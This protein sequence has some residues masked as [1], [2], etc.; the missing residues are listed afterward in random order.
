MYV[1]I[2]VIIVFLLGLYMTLTYKTNDFKESFINKPRCP[3]MLIQDGSELYLYN[4]KLAK[5][6]GVNPIQFKNLEEYSEFMD[7]QRSQGI[8][9]PVLYLQHSYDAQGKMDFVFR[10]DP[11]DPRGG[12]P[13]E[14]PLGKIRKA[15]MPGIRQ[16][17]NAA[18][19]DAPYNVADYPAFD[20]QNQYVGETTP[21]DLMYHS[22]EKFELSDDP[23]DNNW[24]G[25]LFTKE[26]VKS[27][28]YDGDKVYRNDYLNKRTKDI[29][30]LKTSDEQVKK[31]HEEVK[32]KAIE[33]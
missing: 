22:G 2:F 10:P 7:W 5:V 24:G 12:L 28:K 13:S 3:N 25:V 26:S 18:T 4:S 32:D 8:N 23:M 16:L 11:S 20:P 19:D 6:P 30:S 1:I 17:D 15:N 14:L 33:K 29:K 9:C 21:L 27:G 31:A